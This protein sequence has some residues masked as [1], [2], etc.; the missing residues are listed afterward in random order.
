MAM[1]H[2]RQ[3]PVDV[4]SVFRTQDYLFTALAIV[5]TL[6]DPRFTKQCRLLQ[7]GGF[8]A[9]RDCATHTRQTIFT[10]P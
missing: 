4:I 1:H 8:L 9:A 3:V 2:T 10:Q 6:R 5:T 7:R